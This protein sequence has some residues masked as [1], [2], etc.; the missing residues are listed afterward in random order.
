M[1]CI[2]RILAVASTPCAMPRSPRNFPEQLPTLRAILYLGG[3][4]DPA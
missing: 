1:R 4:T 2:R 3:A